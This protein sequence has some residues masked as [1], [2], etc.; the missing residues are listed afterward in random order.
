MNGSLIKILPMK[1]LA[2]GALSCATDGK[3]FVVRFLAFDIA[4]ASGSNMKDLVAD[5]NRQQESSNTNGFD[6][7]RGDTTKSIDTPNS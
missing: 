5:K 4:K 6:G 1:N 3:G 2:V 7:G